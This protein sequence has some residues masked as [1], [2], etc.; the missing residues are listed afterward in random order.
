MTYP[1]KITI[2]VLLAGIIIV[3]GIFGAI[4]QQ[5]LLAAILIEPIVILMIIAGVF[6]CGRI[7]LRKEYF[8]QS[9]KRTKI[10]V[11][12]AGLIIAI[13][14]VGAVT[15][16]LLAAAVAIVLIVAGALLISFLH[17]RIGVR[18][19]L[20]GEGEAIVAAVLFALVGMAV[21]QWLLW[22][23]ALA[24]LFMIQQS[25]SRIEKRLD[26]LENR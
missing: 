11:L 21:S 17:G 4:T 23:V 24:V 1:K 26:M 10:F 6:C 2:F 16:Q 3:I 7:L 8:L 15:M 13:A 14:L 5:L 18:E 25:V 20:P 12:L 9:S 22:A 19:E